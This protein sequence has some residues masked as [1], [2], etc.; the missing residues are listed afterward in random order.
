MAT[1]TNPWIINQLLNNNPHD[2]EKFIRE[3]MGDFVAEKKKKDYLMDALRKEGLEPVFYQLN[4]A[5]LIITLTE[6]N[7]SHPQPIENPHAWKLYRKW[8]ILD[9]P[10]NQMSQL[11]FDYS[12]ARTTY[13]IIIRDKKKKG[14]KAVF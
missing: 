9:G 8:G 1:T 10:F 2:H 12:Q 13:D 6:I 5:Y 14:Y 3:Y 4:D 7:K 11:F